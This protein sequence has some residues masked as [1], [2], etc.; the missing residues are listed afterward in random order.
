MEAFTQFCARRRATARIEHPYPYLRRTVV[1][2]AAQRIR[3][4][5]IERRVNE[6]A[7]RRRAGPGSESS[8]VELRLDVTAAL[9][10]LP[11]RQRACIVLRYLE[12]LPDAEV[13][14]TLGCSV[15]TVK[16]QLHKARVALAGILGNEETS[17]R[18]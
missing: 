2:L 4:V 5:Q 18:V 11:A 10:K 8:A 14:E 1:N 6:T 9:R 15:G 17:D 12:D 13:A 16:S 7:E 3:R